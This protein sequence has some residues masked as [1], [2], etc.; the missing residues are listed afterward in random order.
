MEYLC[1]GKEI[2]D[3]LSFLFFMEVLEV[4]E[5]SFGF[6]EFDVVIEEFC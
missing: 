6:V 3:F 5:P 1:Q 2:K 4:M